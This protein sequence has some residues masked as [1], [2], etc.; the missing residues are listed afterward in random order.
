MYIFQNEFGNLI[1]LGYALIDFYND[2]R[3]QAWSFAHNF[4]RKHGIQLQSEVKH[5]DLE[6][7]IFTVK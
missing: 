6:N 4:A 5:P 3:S 2:A 7:Y 1:T